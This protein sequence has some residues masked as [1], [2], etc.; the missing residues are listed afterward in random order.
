MTNKD[1]KFDTVELTEGVYCKSCG[2]PVI[3]MCCNIDAEPYCNWDWW[4]YCS[5]PICKNH[6]GEGYFQNEI[7]WIEIE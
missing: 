4:K 6:I 5:N 3:D 1:R 7:E 2:W